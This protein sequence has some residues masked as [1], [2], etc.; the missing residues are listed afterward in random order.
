MRIGDGSSKPGARSIQVGNGDVFIAGG[1]V[2]LGHPLGCSGARIITTLLYALKARG[3]GLGLA[4]MCIGM[5]QGLA[6]IIENL[7]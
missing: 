1:A 2:T 4:T 3:G 5:G 6:T 7:E